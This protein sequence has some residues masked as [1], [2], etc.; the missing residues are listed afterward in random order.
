MFCTCTKDCYEEL[1]SCTVNGG[2]LSAIRSARSRIVIGLPEASG[3]YPVY[4][5]EMRWRK[6]A[7]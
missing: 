6:D 2:P 4:A 1:G 7:R 5:K 3:C